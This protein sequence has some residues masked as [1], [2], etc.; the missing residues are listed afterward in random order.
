MSSTSSIEKLYVVLVT[1]GGSETIFAMTLGEL[2]MQAATSSL[3]NAEK[4]LAYA[5]KV[6]AE[7]SPRVVEFERKK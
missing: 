2:H 3:K 7:Y 5:K 1:D 4:M 6:G